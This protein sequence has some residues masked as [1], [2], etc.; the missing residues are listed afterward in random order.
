MC[1]LDA[2]VRNFGPHFVTRLLEPLLED[3]TIGFVKGHYERPLHGNPAA[4]A[5]SPS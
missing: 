4:A 2:D 5:E 3:P 1:F